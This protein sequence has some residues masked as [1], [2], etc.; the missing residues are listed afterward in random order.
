MIVRMKKLAVLV[1]TADRGA[2]LAKLG[3]LGVV[4]VDVVQVAPTEDIRLLEAEQMKLVAAER[5]IGEEVDEQSVEEWMTP[6]YV[7]HILELASRRDL[8]SQELEELSEKLRWYHDWGQISPRSVARLESAGIAVGFYVVDRRAMKELP[9]DR[10]FHVVREA[11]GSDALVALICG[12]GDEKLWYRQDAMPAEEFASLDSRATEVRQQVEAIDAELHELGGARQALDTYRADLARRLEYHRVHEAMG[13]EGRIAYLEGYCPADAVEAVEA[14]AAREGWACM[15]EDPDP[16]RAPVEVRRP[17]WLKPVAPVFE[18][19]GTLPGYL[20]YDISFLFLI[21]FSGFFAL[22]IGD[23]GYG[24]IFLVLTA[25]LRRKFK[26]APGAPFQMLYILS[27][28]TIAWGAVTGTWFGYAGVYELPLLG[29]LVVWQQIASFPRP[30]TEP[31]DTQGFMMYLCFIIGGVHLTLARLTVTARYL[32]H[33]SPVALAEIGWIVV[34]WSMFFVANNLVLGKDLPD[35]VPTTLGLGAGLVLLFQNFQKNVIKGVLQT[36]GNLPL[37]LI[38]SFSDIVSYLRLFAVGYAS[39]VVASSFNAMAEPMFGSAIGSF[40]GAL[41][42][43]LG[44]GLNIILGAMAVIV[45]GIRLNMLEFS[46]HL[47]M[48]W[49]GRPY[50]PFKN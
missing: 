49:S 12:T 18:F 46:G 38:S 42:L 44:H 50:K 40:V 16:E 30:G 35:L 24:A 48:Q 11:D 39:V 17:G 33:R 7:D 31:V 29:D 45:H 28:T 32:V 13:V 15:A 21:F 34:L 3:K 4:H 22:L 14:A 2:A 43:F 41:V 19:M 1:S 27:L 9:A 26:T 37:D 10:I 20:E 25:Y 47:G 8:L 6:D 5:A 23:G 36:L